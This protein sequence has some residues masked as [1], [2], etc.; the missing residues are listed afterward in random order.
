LNAPVRAHLSPLVRRG[1]GLALRRGRGLA[2]GTALVESGMW[3][4]GC[5]YHVCWAHQSLRLRAISGQTW[6]ERTPALV[7]GLTDHRW[8]LAEVLCYR[9]PPADPVSVRAA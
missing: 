2:H 4:V 3:L 7:A 8:T 1:R 5:A 6:R 9:V